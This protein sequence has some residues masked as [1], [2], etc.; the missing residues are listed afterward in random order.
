M[1]T[2]TRSTLVLLIETIN[3]ERGSRN[4]ILVFIAE[5][6]QRLNIQAIPSIICKKDQVCGWYSGIKVRSNSENKHDMPVMSQH[7]AVEVET[8]PNNHLQ[9][10]IRMNKKKMCM[11]DII[12][13]NQ[14]V[15]N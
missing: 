8:T 7:T 10:H 1:S 3:N 12:T 13:N 15:K 9:Q 6:W 14:N 5:G 4:T 2:P 11:N